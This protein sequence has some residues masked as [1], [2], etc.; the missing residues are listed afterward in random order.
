MPRYSST[1]HSSLSPVK[2]VQRGVYGFSWSNTNSTVTSNITISAVD[3][4]KSVCLA[5]SNTYYARGSANWES[6][7]YAEE[8]SKGATAALTSSTNVQTTYRKQS[9]QNSG[10]SL[11]GGNELCWEVVEYI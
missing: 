10:T 2:S 6:T 7:F 11:L 9:I 3:T 1:G 8:R 4:S 5:E